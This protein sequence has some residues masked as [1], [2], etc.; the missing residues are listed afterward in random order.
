MRRI[1]GIAAIALALCFSQAAYGKEKN[2]GQ[3]VNPSQTFNFTKDETIDTTVKHGKTDI[4]FTCYNLDKQQYYNKTNTWL[5]YY[6]SSSVVDLTC[7]IDNTQT[8]YICNNGTSSSHT[9]KVIMKSGCS[10]PN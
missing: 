1:A 8:H 10:N 7:F 6:A 2:L 5:K 9:V 4:F 3:Q